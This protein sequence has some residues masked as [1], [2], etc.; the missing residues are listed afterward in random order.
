MFA[1]LSLLLAVQAALPLPA[2]EE[3]RQALADEAAIA[4][5]EDEACAARRS[6][7]VQVRAV[8]CS[9]AGEDLA[10]C[11]Y[12][13]RNDAGAWRPADARF[14]FDIETQLWFVD[15]DAEGERG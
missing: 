6:E 7:A 9:A 13:T 12:E 14:R 2:E 1:I 10:S 3:V 8:A 5:G 4:C 15:R 11:R